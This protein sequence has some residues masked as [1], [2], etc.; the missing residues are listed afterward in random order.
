MLRD[1]IE[2]ARSKMASVKDWREEG[3]GV[4]L[5]IKEALDAKYLPPWHVSAGKHFG[6]KVTHDAK[7]WISFYLGDYL[8]LMFR[9]S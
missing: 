2:L 5:A 6:S 8:F 3:D 4:V 9:K 7:H 1:C